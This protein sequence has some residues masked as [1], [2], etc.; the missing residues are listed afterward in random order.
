MPAS[1]CVR[2]RLPRLLPAL[3]IAGAAPPLD[4][5]PGPRH[6]PSPEWRD[7]ILYSLMIDR[8]DDADRRRNDQG[9]HEYNPRSNAHFNG[10]DLRGVTRRIGYLKR[11]GVTAVWIS[12]PTATQWWDPATRYTGYHGYWP[13]NFRAVDAHFGALQDYKTLARTLHANGMYLIQD[14]VVNQIGH[15]YNYAG[16]YHPEDNRINFHLN[17]GAV[18]PRP[19]Q[20]PFNLIDRLNPIDAKANVYHWTPSITDYADP[21]TRYTYQLQLMNDINTGNPLVRQALKDAYGYWIREVGVDGFRLDATKHVEP[22]FWRDFLHGPGGIAESAARTGRRDFLTFGEIFNFSDPLRTN[23]EAQIAA[24][25]GTPRDP[26]L[27]AVIN[28]PLYEEVQ[29]VFAGGLPTAYLAFRLAAQARSFVDPRLAPIFVDN[30]DVQRFLAGGS[31]EAYR[32]AYTLLMTAPGIPVIYQGDEQGLDDPRQAMFAGGYRATRDSF[33]EQSP[34]YRFLQRLTA[35]RRAEPALRRGNL[36]IL[37]SSPVGAGVLAFERRWRDERVFVI[38]NTSGTQS[39]LL[40]AMPTGL[41]PGARLETLYARNIGVSPIAGKGGGL[42]LELPPHA[43]LVLKAR[44][45]PGAV[46]AAARLRVDSAPVWASGERVCGRGAAAGGALRLVINGDLANAAPLSADAA[47]RWCADLPSVSLDPAPAVAEVYDPARGVASAPIA[48][49]SLGSVTYRARFDDPAGDDRGPAGTYRPLTDAPD[50]HAADIRAI[51]VRANDR[52][53]ELTLEVGEIKNVWSYINQFDHAAWTLF[54]APPALPPGSGA[55]ALPLL[56]AAMPGGARWAVS[57]RLFGMGST[58]YAAQGATAARFGER[59]DVRPAFVIDPAT[60]RVTITYDRAALG[61]ASWAGARFYLASWDA[62]EFGNY[63]PLDAK[64]G[65]DRLGGGSATAPR[66]LDD[67]A[68]TL[69]ATLAVA[70]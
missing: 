61:L 46:A 18:P 25:L 70:H 67:I 26:L 31:P 43:T 50:H 12:P 27:G 42:T 4:A 64:A 58:V 55:T 48:Y 66:V 3:A 17:K 69:P 59:I 60:R 6:V 30:H 40:N 15:Y 20:Y 65:P 21:A 28:F 47:G 7:Q 19:T 56:N 37:R 68:F 32:L 36:R 2:R 62:D 8:F 53:L 63:R 10:G 49:R 51:A 38:L 14:A 9:H 5:A 24:F 23:G 39:T 57:H 1:R 33:D 16:G 29:R 35:L 54:I 45:A 22:D 34:Y 52:Q 44:G 13:V 41:A 11:L